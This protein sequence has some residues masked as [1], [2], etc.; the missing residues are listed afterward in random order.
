DNAR[1]VE[2]LQ[3][4][5]ADLQARN[6]ELDAFSHMVAHDLKN[7][8]SLTIGYAQFLRKRHT[9]SLDEDA[10]RCLEQIEQ[11]GTKMGNIVDELLLL[12]K[13]RSVDVERVPLDMADIVA[14]AELR[15]TH[16]IQEYEARVIWPETWPTAFGHDAWIEEVSV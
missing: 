4:R 5:T 9:P 11:S 16:M 14:M 2:A 1:L 13:I 15:L 10:Y 7:P 3:A 6:E 12:S 8:L